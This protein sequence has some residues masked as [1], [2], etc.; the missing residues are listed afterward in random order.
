M[1]SLTERRLE[2]RNIQKSREQFL[3]RV[4]SWEEKFGEPIRKRI[5][6]RKESS[7][8]RRSLSAKRRRENSAKEALKFDMFITDVDRKL[9]SMKARQERWKRGEYSK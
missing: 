9:A 5:Q 6:E 4:K 7:S 2:A 8:R 1:P 3:K